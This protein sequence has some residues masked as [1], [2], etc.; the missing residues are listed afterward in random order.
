MRRP[1]Y[2]FAHS[3]R[4]LRPIVKY[5]QCGWF[6][7]GCLIFARALQLWLGGHLAAVIREA[8]YGEQAFDH[9][10]LSWESQAGNSEAW[11]IDANGVSHKAGLLRYW[12][13]RERLRNPI[14]E[15]PVNPVR[16]VRHLEEHSWSDWLARELRKEFGSPERHEIAKILGSYS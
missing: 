7:G 5:Y 15:D 3:P 10:V 1:L 6:D 8:F 11:Y 4:I 16:F 9:C 14:L 13:S 2:K 12:R